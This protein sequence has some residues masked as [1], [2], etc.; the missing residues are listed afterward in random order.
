M[1]Y[2]YSTRIIGNTL[3]SLMIFSFLSA[4]PFTASY[5]QETPPAP[6]KATP[7]DVVACEEEFMKRENL[8]DLGGSQYR[9]KIKELCKKSVHDAPKVEPGKEPTTNE[10]YF[11]G[12][13]NGFVYDLSDEC[14]KVR[15]QEELIFICPEGKYKPT[16]RNNQSGFMP[17]I[18]PGTQ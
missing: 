6:K 14:Q 3:R 2:S 7:A 16:I 9:N 8:P 4:F 11:S 5:A 17:Y 10:Y 1:N 13:N 12:D 15:I 18:E